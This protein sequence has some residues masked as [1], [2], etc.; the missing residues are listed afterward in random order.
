MTFV[1][2]GVSTTAGTGSG[3]GSALGMS[4]SPASVRVTPLSVSANMF[5]PSSVSFL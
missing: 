3:V 5:K 4:A 1:T 2:F